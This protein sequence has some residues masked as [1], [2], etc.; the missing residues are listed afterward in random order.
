M[1]RFNA[2]MAAYSDIT[3]QEPNASSGINT[4]TDLCPSSKPLIPTKSSSEKSSKFFYNNEARM[5]ANA[6]IPK[7]SLAIA[8]E[9]RETATVAP[10][11]QTQSDNSLQL[12][13]LTTNLPVDWNSSIFLRVDESR[14]DVIKVLITGPEGTP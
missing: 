9:V 11:P 10:A 13:V 7:R 3:G 1:A 6:D 2:I 5:L 12:A 8:K 4:G 14:V